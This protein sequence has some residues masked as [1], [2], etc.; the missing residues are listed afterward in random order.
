[1][2]YIEVPGPADEEIIFPA[3]D[4]GPAF[5]WGEYR[6][7][8]KMLRTLGID[9]PVRT[10]MREKL[11]KQVV[12]FGV[13]LPTGREPLICE[14]CKRQEYLTHLPEC[15]DYDASEGITRDAAA[16][17]YLTDGFAVVHT[18]SAPANDDEA[19]EYFSLV[20]TWFPDVNVK[21]VMRK[22]MYGDSE[23]KMIPWS[24][25]SE[26]NEVTEIARP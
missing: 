6:A 8:E 24:Y 26:A 4:D 19:T 16:Y 12:R 2:S 23:F 20:Q 11:D 17:R 22:E 7:T 14:H 1:M 3:T 21:Y 15:P 25:D 9:N 5:T 18:T 10:Q 13:Q